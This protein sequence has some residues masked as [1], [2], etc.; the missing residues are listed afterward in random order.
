MPTQVTLI[1]MLKPGHE[2]AY[3]TLHAR[4][5][6]DLLEAHRRA[7]IHDWRIWRSGL[8][9]FHLVECDDFDAA[10][11]YLDRD[12]A[13]ERWQQL[14]GDLVDHFEQTAGGSWE[15]PLVWHMQEQARQG[16]CDGACKTVA[17]IEPESDA[18]E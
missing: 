13:N 16:G 8:H 9:V 3:D 11:H 4:V 14:V 5:P 6:D 15:L 10:I 17:L 18:D 12:P 7:G 2:E 1:A